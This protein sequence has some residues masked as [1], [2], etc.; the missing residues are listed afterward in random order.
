MT[1]LLSVGD[2]DRTPPR[3]PPALTLTP[4]FWAGA[5]VSRMRSAISPVTSPLG[6][7]SS[8]GVN[9]V[10]ASLL[11]SPEAELANGSGAEATCGA[12]ASAL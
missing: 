8:A 2:L 6:M 1:S 9:A 5:V 3:L 4:A 10:L 12:L 7:S 11:T